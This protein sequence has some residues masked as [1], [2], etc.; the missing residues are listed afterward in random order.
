M[1]DQRISLL[2]G[3]LVEY[4]EYYYYPGTTTSL[5]VNIRTGDIGIVMDKV[6][7]A[8]GYVMYDV[9]WLR[10]GQTTRHVRANLKLAYSIKS[11]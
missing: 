7:N 11:D 3:D 2:K 1:D 9:L 5:N 8:L 6:I 10:T 4:T